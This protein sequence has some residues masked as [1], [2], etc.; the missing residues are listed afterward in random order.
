MKCPKCGRGNVYVSHTDTHAEEI[1]RCRKCADCGAI[2]RTVERL[3]DSRPVT[4]G[5]A[6]RRAE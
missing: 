4:E 5:R 3:D 1:H 6:K 2:F